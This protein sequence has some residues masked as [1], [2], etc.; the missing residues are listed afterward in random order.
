[1][2][3]FSLF[4][5]PGIDPRLG[6]YGFGEIINFVHHY[7]KL[8]VNERSVQPDM[9]RNVKGERN[10]L[11]RALP[12]FLKN[13][14]LSEVY[15]VIGG[16]GASTG[17]SNLGIVKMPDRISSYIDRFDFLPPPEPTSKCNCGVVSFGDKVSISFGRT[18]METDIEKNFFTRLVGMG[19]PV[20]IETN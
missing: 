5:I 17:L 6:R 19:I 18:I 4:L 14:L 13:V 16:K 15:K 1:M 9:A 12:L 7:V 3:N 10:I 11:I 8:N 2:R 20:K